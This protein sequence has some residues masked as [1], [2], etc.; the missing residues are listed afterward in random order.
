MELALCVAGSGAGLAFGSVAAG[1]QHYLYLNPEHR[2]L[3]AAGRK[4]ALMRLLLGLASG[5]VVGVAL[6]PDHY[7]YGPAL[8]TAG[9]G[10]AL[11][12]IASTDFERRIIPNRLSYPAMGVAVAV[13]WA[14]PDRSTLDIVE[15]AGFALGVAAVL[16]GLGMLFGAN[17]LGMG[18]AKLVVL[19]GLIIG[20]PGV[21]TALFFGVI[22][23]GLPAVALLV[24]GGR[25]TYYSYGPYL[26]LGG[27]VVML[28]PERFF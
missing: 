20:W 1:F 9:F 10:V 14:W 16:F 21:M 18:D 7:D 28:W 24:A 27:L 2:A 12:V 26:I 15:G 13:C 25:R 22:A 11:L 4:L 8:L 17:A 6:R 23:A 3:P 19:L 5:T